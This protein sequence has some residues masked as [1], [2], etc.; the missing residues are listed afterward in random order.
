MAW[1]HDQL[2][3]TESLRGEKFKRHLGSIVDAMGIGRDDIIR[4]G[5]ASA[6]WVWS[7]I[8]RE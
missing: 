8:L 4:Y 7:V 5:H 6:F 3:E 2:E 1:I